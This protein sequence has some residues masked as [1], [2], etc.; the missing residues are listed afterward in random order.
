MGLHSQ[1][2]Q[3]VL[4]HI[5]QIATSQQQTESKFGNGRGKKLEQIKRKFFL[6]VLVSWAVCLANLILRRLYDHGSLC[7]SFVVSSSFG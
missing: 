4:H 1:A 5:G 3:V 2:L 6:L 7:C